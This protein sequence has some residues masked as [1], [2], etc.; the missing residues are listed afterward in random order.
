MHEVEEDR[1]A[2]DR[3]DERD[4]RPLPLRQRAGNGIEHAFHGLGR[5]AARQAAGIRDCADQF[6]LVHGR[7]NPLASSYL[8]QVESPRDGG[9]LS[10]FCH[11]WQ[12][13]SRPNRAV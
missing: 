2:E 5:I 12:G 1:E 6:V 7:K 3:G 8:V 11:G 13:Q 10:E 9:E 4:L